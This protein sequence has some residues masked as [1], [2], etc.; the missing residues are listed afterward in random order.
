MKTSNR[1]LML[2]VL[3]L[4]FGT[5]GCS[6]STPHPGMA[7]WEATCSSCHSTG[8]AGAPLIGDEKA[9]NKR[10]TRGK[11]SLYGHA[12]NGWGDMPA[13]GGNA[14]LSDDQVKLAVDY[15]LSKIE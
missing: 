9:W 5:I 1:L 11:D 13:R 3:G 14:E 6:D 4:S 7:I 15:M 10:L 8:L 2:S 12:I